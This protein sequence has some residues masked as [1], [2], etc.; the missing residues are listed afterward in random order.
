MARKNLIKS[1]LLSRRNKEREANPVSCGISAKTK[2][3][4][5][6]ILRRPVKVTETNQYGL[7]HYKGNWCCF[8]KCKPVK[9][10]KQRGSYWVFLRDEGQRPVRGENGAKT[11]KYKD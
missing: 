8:K 6:A 1:I 2:T 11:I 9:K 10:G 4:K 7:A 5:S 3:D